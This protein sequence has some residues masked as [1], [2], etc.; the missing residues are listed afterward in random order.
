MKT[1]QFQLT[2]PPSAL[3]SRAQQIAREQG[4][5]FEGDERQGRFAMMGIRGEYRIENQV[6]QVH[7]TDKPFL[8]PW[9]LVDSQIKRFFSN[10]G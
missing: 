9:V 7:I 10:R 8:I 5:H 2:H 4:A 6:A 1:Y 3:V